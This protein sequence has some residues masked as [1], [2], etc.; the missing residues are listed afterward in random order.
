MEK[1]ILVTGGAGYIGSH[2][3]K[4]LIESGYHVVA[5]DDMSS[6]HAKAIGSVSFEKA[7]IGD[8]G[9][10]NEVFKKYDIEAL[11]HFASRIV[12]S[13][14]VK[15]PLMYYAQNVAGTINVLQA[16]VAHGVKK[17]IFS[18]SAAVYG[19]PDGNPIEESAAI[20]PISPYG[21]SKSI[22][23]GILADAGKAYQLRSVSL[24]YFNATGANPDSTN[25]EDHNPE[26]HLIPLVL[27]AAINNAPVS[28]FGNDYETPDG[29]CIRDYIHVDDLAS[30]HV[31]ALK[32]LLDGGASK[33]LNL[34]NGKG[35]SIKEVVTAVEKVT[36]LKVTMSFEKRREG[37]PAV[38]VASSDKAKELLHWEPKYTKLEDIIKTSYDWEKKGRFN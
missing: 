35:F 36:G 37:D 30:A 6:G 8:K 12:V 32:Y 17:I 26:T 10:M 18:S 24:R 31:L 16:M 29:T 9:A 33:A 38:L 15:D 3:V 21:K 19:T 11:I 25:G 4:Q 5:L 28:I 34:G 27:R 2:T 23:E 1:N 14:S 13:E 20:R 22:V 7:D